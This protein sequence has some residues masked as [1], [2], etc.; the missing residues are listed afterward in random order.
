MCNILGVSQHDKESTS[1]C[2][3]E[4]L[5]QVLAQMLHTAELDMAKTVTPMTL[6]SFLTAWH[7][8]FALPITQ[9][10]KPLQAIF[11]CNMLFNIPFI[12]DW[13]K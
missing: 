1:K 9:S 3:L 2:N 6:M 13:N 10:L 12:A 5:H 11:G 4:H 8:P 7:G